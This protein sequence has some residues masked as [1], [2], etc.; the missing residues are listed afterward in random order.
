MRPEIFKAYDV[1]GL[2]P[3]ELDAGGAEAIGRAIARYLGSQGSVIV[4]RDMRESGV[5]LRAALVAGLR[6]EGMAVI[7]IGRVATPMLYFATTL[8]AA[9]G[10][11]M[12]TASHNPAD[13]NGLKVCAASACP[14]GL[15]SGLN[16]IRDLAF[17]L[18]S[19]EP[20]PPRADESK[21]DVSQ[22]YFDSLL[23][24]FPA[25][26][27]VHLVVD[28]GNGIAGEAVSGL[29]ER[30]PLRT[31][32]LY[33]EPDGTFPN[34]EADPL[35]PENLRDLQRAV[36]D[37]GADLGLAFDGDGDRAVFVD[38]LGEPI[39]AD[40]MTAF[41]ADVV[42]ERGLLG[43]AAGATLVHDL[44]SSRVVAET[45]R[46]RGA[47]PVRSRVGHAFMKQSMR[48]SGACFGGELSG[49]YYFRFPAGYVA[50]DATAALL[51]LLQA[52]ELR[53]L[54]LS[55]LWQPYR[56]YVQSGEINRTVADVK[57]TLS[58]V[59]DAYPDAEVDELDGLTLTFAD[60]WFNLRPSNTEPLLRLN[61]EAPTRPEMVARREQVLRLIDATG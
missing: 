59:R 52:I 33:F 37:G 15:E 57:T 13:Y 40:L 8:T 51:L 24:L 23:A 28:A 5:A 17:A 21:R 38:E 11:V 9:A 39:A 48:D 49:H 53:G 35:K 36:L 12:V 3:E 19:E 14:V 25:C 22:P 42:L 44:R 30:L 45:I 10:G 41:L 55:R 18:E 29:L 16:E 32:R 20:G 31:T 4:G 43:S 6:S 46:A 54:P 56:S 47:E 26:P 58:R 34:H 1:R 27:P 50:D 61:L 2:V 7:D 60:W